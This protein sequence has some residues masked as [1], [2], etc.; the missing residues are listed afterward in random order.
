VA[1]VPRA[2]RKLPRQARR[3]HFCHGIIVVL[4]RRWIDRPCELSKLRAMMTYRITAVLCL[5]GIAAGIGGCSSTGSQLLTTG[6]LFGNKTK[7]TATAPAPVVVKPSDRAIEVAAVSARAQ[8]CGYYFDSAK[9]RTTYL[10]S[11]AQAGADPAALENLTKIYDYT[12]SKLLKVLADKE[13]YCSKD[14]LRQIKANLTRHL[15][16][17]FAPPK[18]KKQVASGWFDLEPEDKSDEKLNPDWVNYPD[19]ESQTKKVDPE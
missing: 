19:R 3:P 16:G 1:C 8:K 13:D 7:K 18:K 2:R 10:A 9:L 11:E 15:A 17:D 4:G 14:R 6:S 12:N 5:L